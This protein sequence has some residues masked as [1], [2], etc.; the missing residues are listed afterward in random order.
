MLCLLQTH[1]SQSQFS[2]SCKY[3]AQI[4]V[5]TLLLP[6]GIAVLSYKCNML[7]LQPPDVVTIF[8]QMMPRDQFDALSS[9]TMALEVEADP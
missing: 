7:D 2:F 1:F 9:P 6:G 4:P 3:I 8:P 5:D